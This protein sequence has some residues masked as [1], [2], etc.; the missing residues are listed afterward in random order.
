MNSVQIGPFMFAAGLFIVLVSFITAMLVAIVLDKRRK[1]RA[2]N[3]LFWGACWAVVAGR[4]AYVVQHWAAFVDQPMAI[5]DVRDGNL[6]V[7]L[8]L[9]A[10]FLYW[11]WRSWRERAV[12]M[13]LLYSV[14]AGALLGLVL[15][16]TLQPGQGLKGQSL[17]HLSLE[18][19][20]PANQAITLREFEGKPIVLNLWASWCGPCR[21]EMP[22][23]QQAQQE[24]PEVHFVFLN[25][26][27]RPEQAMSFLQAEGLALE[28]VYADAQQQ[29]LKASQSAGLPTTL[30]LDAQGRVLS[31]RA[32]E[33]SLPALR[34]VLKDLQ[35]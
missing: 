22:A 28:H 10:A 34:A 33:L 6:N 17:A 23:F 20:E 18:P 24:H 1:T 12:A 9:C 7:V 26:G 8:G 19:L 3:A 35:P 21:R 31:V 15:N 13:P 25:Q 30:F 4:L 29:G 27:E 11:G 5:I 32:G 16:L 14:G 2:E